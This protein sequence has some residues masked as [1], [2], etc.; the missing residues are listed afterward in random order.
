MSRPG[1][2]ARLH[3]PRLTRDASLCFGYQFRDP[4]PDELRVAA[5]QA[6]AAGFDVISSWDHVAALWTPLLPL[7]AVA[8]ATTK[9]RVCPLVINNDFHHPVHLAAAIAD[10][11]VLTDGRVELRIGAGH[12]FTEY[13]G[14]ASRSTHLRCANNA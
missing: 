11:D 8:E 5:C 4:E 7:L 14:S 12:A 3:L 9:V 2:T 6:E 13:A 1:A 10:L